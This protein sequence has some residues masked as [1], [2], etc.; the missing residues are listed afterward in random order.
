L[1]IEPNASRCPSVIVAA[2]DSARL[3]ASA[4]RPKS[5]DAATAAPNTPQVPVMCQ[6]W[7]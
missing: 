4:S 7:S 5:A 2:S 3:A 1:H 6:P